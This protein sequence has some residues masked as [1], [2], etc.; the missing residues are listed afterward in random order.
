MPETLGRDS[1]VYEQAG[2]S[3]ETTDDG[4]AKRKQGLYDC[5]IWETSSIVVNPEFRPWFVHKDGKV[6]DIANA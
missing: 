5:L 6:T 4:G 3:N 2:P 1:T